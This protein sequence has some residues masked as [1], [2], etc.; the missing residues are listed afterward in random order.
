VNGVFIAKAAEFFYFHTVGMVLFFL[1]GIVVT[2]LAIHAGQGDFR[3]HND[4]LIF[5]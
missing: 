4:L 5:I 1:G 2:L 3:S